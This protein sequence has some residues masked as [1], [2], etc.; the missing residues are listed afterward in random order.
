MSYYGNSGSGSSWQSHNQKKPSSASSSSSSAPSN[1][2]DNNQSQSFPSNTLIAHFAQA[3]N[4]GLPNLPALNSIAPPSSGYGSWHS[5]NRLASSNSN[6]SSNNRSS[7][8]NG[9][10]DSYKESS[11]GLLSPPSTAYSSSSRPKEAA[12]SLTG[13]SRPFNIQQ[14]H[15]SANLMR[16]PSPNSRSNSRGSGPSSNSHHNSNSGSSSSSAVRYES[17]LSDGSI[18]QFYRGLRWKSLVN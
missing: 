7:S 15:N 18:G 13:L 8:N 6:S 10:S 2:P 5:Q 11:T 14:S 16:P 1:K 4:F 12:F 3:H 9:K 17:K